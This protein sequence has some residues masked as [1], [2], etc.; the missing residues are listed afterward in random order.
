MFFCKY[1][2]VFCFSLLLL[3]TGSHFSQN[4]KTD[5]L[6][7]HWRAE[8]D[9]TMKVKNLNWI[10]YA[11]RDRSDSALIVAKEALTLAQKL[12]YR[13]GAATAYANTGAA[14]KSMGKYP[15]ALKNELQAQKLYE[16]CKSQK[17]L[18]SI[19]NNIGTIFG[20]LNN[21]E[22]ALKNYFEALEIRKAIKDE[23]GS[24]NAHVNV[25]SILVEMKKFDE[26][27]E[28][29]QQAL[30][31]VE[32]SKNKRGLAMVYNNLGTLEQEKKND[33]LAYQMYERSYSYSK[34]LK[35]AYLMGAALV[36]MGSLQIKF[37]NYALAQKLEME[38]LALSREI[39]ST[40]Q[41]IEAYGNL[42]DI[43]AATKKYEMEYEYYMRYYSLRDSLLS[44]E[45]MRKTIQLEMQFDFDKKQAADSVRNAEHQLKEAIKHEQ[46]IQKQKTITYGGMAGLLLMII[47]MGVSLN[48][49]RAKQKANKMISEQKKLVEE[50]QKEV[51]ESIY[52]A[53]RIQTALI[54][55]EKQVDKT[56]RRLMKLT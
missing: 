10:S 34:I 52:Y 7:K 32:T 56:L 30:I 23:K 44:Q 25:G 55:S 13:Y 47:V 48:A 17:D 19:H 8:K 26:A 38:A 2:K 35:D 5:S 9:D 42:G 37:K 11:L 51:L 28:H 1:I 41:A 4:R 50:K 14:Y 27:N 20:A 45:K 15:E 46:E 54:A 53:K 22:E 24:V 6:L 33:D 18:A 3:N 43:A 36:N 21:Y 40:E 16:E 31:I 29:F 12:N 49:Y 39:G